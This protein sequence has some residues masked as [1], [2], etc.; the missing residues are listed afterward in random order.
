MPSSRSFVIVVALATALAGPAAD[1]AP[2]Q[3]GAVPR[4]SAEVRPSS[5]LLPGT[6]AD[7]FATI[8]GNALTSTSAPMPDANVRLRDARRGE[9]VA[10]QVTDKEG[11]F[12]FAR[13]DPG[14]Y[15]VELVGADR[16]VLAAS[17]LL[18]IESGQTL[19][20]VVKLPTRIR[21][22]A[23]LLGTNTA[24]IIAVVGAAAASGV[25]ATAVVGQ[26]ASPVNPVRERN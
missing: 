2:Q 16:S 26:P 25:L 15:V 11:L 17:E 22:V 18:S 3:T 20:T 8:Q 9:I 4:A 1:A 10:E 12:G 19:S 24:S 23:G 13:V 5:P 21:P 14:V 7:V 6:R